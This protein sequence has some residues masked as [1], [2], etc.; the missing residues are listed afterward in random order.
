M[1]KI[2]FL[3][4]VWVVP[5]ISSIGYAED[6]PNVDMSRPV[7]DLSGKW[8]EVQE[9]YRDD[10][11]IV[12]V[13]QKGNHIEGRYLKVSPFL[14]KYFGFKV[15]ELVLTGDIDGDKMT[16]YL[17]VKPQMDFLKGCPQI[18]TIKWVRVVFQIN[19][20]SDVLNG[21]WENQEINFEKCTLG[22]MMKEAYTMKKL[23]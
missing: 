13:T 17:L 15:G 14:A 22:R 9:V 11:G 20:G 3:I 4:V 19:A 21:D 18:P 7:A 2:L 12:E 1:R 6:R 8:M 5:V 16:G 23:P 10:H